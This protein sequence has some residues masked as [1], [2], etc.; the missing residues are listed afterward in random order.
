MLNIISA[1]EARQ[2][3]KKLAEKKV[4]NEIRE[5]QERGVTE[6]YFLSAIPFSI[7]KQLREKGYLVDDDGMFVS[8]A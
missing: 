2:N 6:C 8:W 4:E 7:I 3:Y 1:D 5:A